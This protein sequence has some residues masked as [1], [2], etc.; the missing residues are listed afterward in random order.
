MGR[1][2]SRDLT[3]GSDLDLI[4]LYDHDEAADCS[5]GDKPL[6]ASQYF[7]RLTQRLIAAMSAPT[8]EGVIFELDF[9]LR[10]S[11]N[12][13]PLATSV[14]SFLKYQEN[15][16]WT[17][18]RQALTRARTVAGDP[19]LCARLSDH[20]TRLLAYPMEPKK[21]AADIRDMR[22]L[23]DKEKPADGPFDVKN[24]P[25]GMMDIEFI[26]QW[27]TL[28]A[29]LDASAERAT[30]IDGLI[31]QAD[32]AILSA[33]DRELLTRA[34]DAY[35]RCLQLTRVCIDGAFDPQTAPRGLRELMCEAFDLPTIEAVGAHLAD[36]QK[37]VRA[38]FRKLIG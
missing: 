23:I 27:A 9:R 31:G 36:L 20:I 21:L 34:L 17:W 12:A 38:R 11:G 37:Q 16:A 35:N 7:I 14:V 15:E 8:A 28:R 33:D 29:G 24:A 2:G 30:S 25:G 19:A 18:E 32:P 26:A 10:P 5:N 22:A 6:A 3:A 1:L 13:G 4:L